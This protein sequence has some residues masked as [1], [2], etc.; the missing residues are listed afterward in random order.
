M[1]IQIRHTEPGSVFAPGAFDRSVGK[2]IP[3]NLPAGGSVPGKLVA[4]EVVD[5][6]RAVLMTLEV[7]GDIPEIKG[8]GSGFSFAPTE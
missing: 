8:S 4:A 6:G 7:D 1:R 3:V 2:T 5:G